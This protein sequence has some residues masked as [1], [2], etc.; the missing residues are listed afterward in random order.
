MVLAAVEAQGGADLII[1][2][3]RITTQASGVQSPS[4]VAARGGKILAVGSDQDVLA[5]RAARTTVVDAQGRRLIPG[6]NDSHLH[7]TREARYYAA[8]L[9]WDGVPTLE[10]A[11]DMVRQAAANT[12]EGQWVRVVGGWSPY[13]FAEKRMPTPAELTRVAPRTPVF[14]LHLYSGGIYNKKGVEVARLSDTPPP[15]GGTIETGTDGQPTG[16]I[17]A[18]PRPTILYRAVGQLGELPADAQASSARHFYRELNRFGLTSAIDAG[19][20]GHAY[21]TQYA[22]SFD[23]ARTDGLPLRISYY[24][25]AQ[26]PGQELGDIQGWADSERLNAN[27][28]AHHDN[29]LVLEGAGETLVWSAG[30][31]ENFR[32]ERP[33]LD[34]N[35]NWREELTAAAR[36]LVRRRWPIRIHAT[37]DETIDRIL[38]VFET[39][40]REERAAGRPGFTDLRWA[41]DH[42]ETIQV[43]QIA[44]IKALGGGVMIQNRMAFA[45]EDF[46][47]RYGQEAAGH[48][49]PIRQL[50]AAGLPLGLG[51]DGTRVSSYNPWL[52]LYWLVSGKSVGGTPLLSTVNRLDRAK[53]LEL[54]TVGSAWFSGE[55][56]VKGRIAPG[57][58]ADMA[59][60]SADYFTVPEEEIRRIESVLT[61]TGGDLV[62]AAGPYRHLVPELEPIL[63]SWSPVRT[64]GGY[65]KTPEK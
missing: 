63:P 45:G 18:T 11:L 62:Y 30:D 16:R 47:A 44:R 21:P 9:R 1:Y 46:I 37:Y 5:L 20:G 49:P 7:P 57:Q 10:R 19:G 48:A 24:L 26:K 29:G 39:V 60:L 13:Q 34:A 17:L 25:F 3:A 58:Y 32:A 61:I 43:A 12:P 22:A 36:T 28:D 31:F 8:E 33:D 27:L 52:S 2:N 15:E 59:L 64:F 35:P 41:F 40:D 50:L 14:V 65:Y 56:D 4:A 42:V 51:T 6:L 53:A 23:M 38:S 55:E 54:Y